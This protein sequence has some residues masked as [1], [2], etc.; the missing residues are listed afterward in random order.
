MVTA[1]SGR[2]A[3]A[4]SNRRPAAAILAMPRHEDVARRLSLC[5]GVSTVV[6]PEATSS[7]AMLVRGIDWAKSQGLV[8]AGQHA[9]LLRHRVAD[10]SDIRAVLAGVVR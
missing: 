10:R 1:T 7:D 9:V 5:W 6:F 4:L 3:L 2:T 8:Q